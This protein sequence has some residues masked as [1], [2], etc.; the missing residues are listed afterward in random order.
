MSVLTRLITAA[1]ALVLLAGCGTTEAPVTEPA[2]SGASGAASVTATD[3]TGKQITLDGPATKVVGLEWNVVEMLLTLDV[4]PVGVADVEGYNSWDKVMPVAADTVDV[5]LRGEP[6]VE[7]IA[8]TDPDLIIAIESSIPEGAMAQLEQIAPVAVITAADASRQ[9][10]LIKDNLRFIATLTGTEPKADQVITE[11]D[12]H[13]AEVKEKLAA[14]PGAQRPFVMVGAFAEGNTVSFR[15]HGTGSTPGAVAEVLGLTNAWDGE[16]DA[17]YGLG[18][19][20]L[21][22]LTTLP[23]DTTILYWGN[24]DTPD[25]V[26]TVLSKNAVWQSLPSVK[27]GYVA[28]SANGIWLYGGT[29]SM[30]AWADELVELLA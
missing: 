20:D 22:A 30:S 13:L 6:S 17:A 23:D 24:D 9:L 4:A 29:A 3:S 26:T 2:A 25:A 5:G 15:M 12:A 27:S 10:D 21:E 16:D 8:R 18:S 28:S 1:A 19:A 11:F 7:A 14:L